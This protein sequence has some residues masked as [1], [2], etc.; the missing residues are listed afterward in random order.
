MGEFR[1][2]AIYRGYDRAGLDAQYNCRGM[3]PD[4]GDHMARWKRLSEDACGRFEMRRDLAY[5]ASP[6]ERLDLF[7]PDGAGPHP[8]MIFI[9]GGYWRAM[10]KTSHAFPALGFVPDGIALAS[11]DYTLAP[12]A[13]MDRIVRECR[14]AVA[15]CRTNAADLGIDPGRI[16]VSGHSAG[17]HLTAMM[18]TTD[19]PAFGAGLPAGLVRTGCPISGLYDLEPIRLTYLND[20]V[21]LDEAL[22][23]RNSPVNLV[24]HGPRAMVVA[25]GG[26]ESD[27]FHR[28]QAVLVQRW[29]DEIPDIEAVDMPGCHHFNVVTAL[30][31]PENPLCRAA[32]ARIL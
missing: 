25:A 17:G 31:E 7:L 24:P 23:A 20:D 21:R 32:K 8:L 10:D 28:Q 6:G 11:I 3:V 13:D 19:W 9:H 26:L 30:A 15:W 27:E 16:H 29:R 22:A 2:E 12:V 1:G 18:M 14:T 5:G 4:V